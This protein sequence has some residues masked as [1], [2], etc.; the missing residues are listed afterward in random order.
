M[1]KSVKIE[2]SMEA[3]PSSP[4]TFHEQRVSSFENLNCQMSRVAKTW[5]Y[6]SSLG[7]SIITNEGRQAF[8]SKSEQNVA[9]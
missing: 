3:S 5:F 1:W 6:L 4:N 7:V 2:A 9:N 8:C